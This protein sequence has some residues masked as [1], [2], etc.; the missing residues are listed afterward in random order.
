MCMDLNEYRDLCARPDVI[1]RGELEETVRALR[2]LRSPDVRLVEEILEQPPIE[3]PVVHAAGSEADSFF[4]TLDADVVESIVEQLTD[5]E[6][7]AVS[8]AGETTPEA[9]RL[10]ELVDLWACCQEYLE[11]GGAA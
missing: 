10:A 3:K 1:R 8:P 4:V 9:G 2:R 5:A 6:A 11:N 7:A